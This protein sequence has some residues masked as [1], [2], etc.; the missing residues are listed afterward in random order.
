MGE[1]I[2]LAAS[3]IALG[4]VAVTAAKVSIIMVEIANDV[5]WARDD[6]LMFGYASKSFA[7]LLKLS[8]DELHHQFNNPNLSP[9]VRRIKDSN[10][11][12]DLVRQAKLLKERIKELTP[13]IKG[14]PSSIGIVTTLKWTFQKSRVL[15][16]APHM[17]GIET[18]LNLIMAIVKLEQVQQVAPSDQALRTM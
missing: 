2:G 18:S 13:K 3:L 5:K 15:A 8:R 1:V 7:S 14:L 16:L 11:M 6:I 17:K 10:V 12:G 4:G 9:V